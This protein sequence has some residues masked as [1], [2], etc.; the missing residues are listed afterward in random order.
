MNEWESR[1]AAI[2]GVVVLLGLY[3]AW[4]SKRSG[5]NA[6]E[7]VPEQQ[8]GAEQDEQEKRRRL[9]SIKLNYLL[10]YALVM[11]A[12]WLQG[13]YIYSLYHDEFNY[14]I[15][16]VAA[17]FV[18]G[19]LSAGLLAPFV[20]DWA[21]RFGRRR[22]CLVFT[23]AYTLSCATKMIRFL[24]FLILGRLL[25]G[26]STS[27]LFSVFESWLV[28]S[29]LDR[30][31]HQ[32]ELN[33][34]LGR[35]T[36][37]NGGV[38][39]GAGMLSNQVVEAFGTFKA[40]FVTSAG[41]L[42]VAGLVIS[43]SWSENYGEK[44]EE[45]AGRWGHLVEAVR[46]VQND[47][48]L[49]YLLAV[50]TA[51]EASMYLFVFLWVPTLQSTLS[52]DDSA[53][54]LGVIFSSFM[55]CLSGGSIIYNILHFHLS[56]CAGRNLRSTAKAH[57]DAHSQPLASSAASQPTPNEHAPLIPPPT[58][59]R[60]ASKLSLERIASISFNSRLGSLV[61]MAAGTLLLVSTTVESAKAKFWCFV[62]FE[63][64]VGMYYPMAASLRSALIAEEHRA[65]I[66]ALFRVPLNLLV[67]IALLSG[68]ESRPRDVFILCFGALLPASGMA[69]GINVELRRSLMKE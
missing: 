29:A 2:G 15:R 5:S 10:I 66:T 30:G 64:A 60:G 44:K 17:L 51:F 16:I 57:R 3:D 14:S 59:Q 13:P 21:D 4:R 37:V 36:L 52:P 46:V 31:M 49:L 41:F 38:A 39:C 33:S 32:S 63:I 43:A 20:G 8:E 67:T 24:P 12:D 25:G 27:I 6:K 45:T 48:S 42:V 47:S 56:A 55:V 28:S 23:A 68:L 19:F 7:A 9:R 34:F 50:I 61:L 53:L 22:L 54:P 11:T 1:L 26:F 18:L 35:L 58:S 65:T 62:A 69:L 40:P